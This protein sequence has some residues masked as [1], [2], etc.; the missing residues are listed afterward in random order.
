MTSSGFE[1]LGGST[2]STLEGVMGKAYSTLIVLGVAIL[3]FLLINY[4]LRSVS[5]HKIAKR[6]HIKGR[7]LAWV[8]V[9][10]VYVLGAIASRH[11][12]KA[13]LVKRRWGILLLVTLLVA[14][15]AGFATELAGKEMHTRI[16]IYADNVAEGMDMAPVEAAFQTL[17]QKALEGGAGLTSAA[18]SLVSTFVDQ[19]TRAASAVRMNIRGVL[20]LL[21]GLNLLFLLAMAAFKFMSGVCFFKL[22]ESCTPKAAVCLTLLL[23]LVPVTAPFILLAVSGKDGKRDRKKE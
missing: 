13:V 19:I 2:A 12:K 20:L 18:M 9:L 17:E 23:M 3:A 15:A 1:A 6:R 21:A 10:W 16:M 22:I 5:L 7:A 11:D 8:P 4:I 14:G